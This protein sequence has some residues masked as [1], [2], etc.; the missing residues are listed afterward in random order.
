VIQQ[1][2]RSS[3][4]VASMLQKFTKH[5]ILASCFLVTL[6][7]PAYAY[8]GGG[9]TTAHPDLGDYPRVGVVTLEYGEPAGS[10][11]VAFTINKGTAI[12]VGDLV[13][14]EVSITNT[15]ATEISKVEFF[16]DGALKQASISKSYVW[17]TRYTSPGEHAT[18]ISTTDKNGQV[19]VSAKTVNVNKPSALQVA[20]TVNKGLIISAGAKVPLDVTVTPDQGVKKIEY[21]VDDALKQSATAKSY[22]WDT[23]Y[24][25]PGSHAVKVKVTDQNGLSKAVTQ[26]VTV[27]KISALQVAFTANKGSSIMVGDKVPLQVSLIPDVA[28]SKI[29][30]LVDNSL[31]Q[32]NTAK[33]YTWDTTHTSPGNHT[34]TVKV[35]DQSGA[36]KSST[37]TVSVNKASSLR[38][39][40]TI[41]K[42]SAITVGAMVPLE[43]S[44]TSAVAT[45]IS[46]VAFYVDNALK[47]ATTSKSYLWNTKYTSPGAHALK[48]IATDKNGQATVLTQ[49]VTV[50]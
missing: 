23:S 41:N 18:K 33:S 15:A 50:K 36:T 8:S 24:T 17:N 1:F 27:N 2:T 47:Q 39:A 20:L 30:F 13:P 12:T 34:L 42:G 4:E 35:T 22:A 37:Q 9:Q 49:T 25:S 38:L 5:L 14:I 44:V 48:I 19:I 3:K 16:V 29:A 6:I 28:V 26:T 7:V 10:P 43:V 11:N 32:A 46:T 40:C 31:K 21:F 45:E